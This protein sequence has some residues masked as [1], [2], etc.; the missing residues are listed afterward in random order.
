MI[1][2]VSYDARHSQNDDKCLQISE[3]LSLIPE[4]CIYTHTHKTTEDMCVHT[5]PHTPNAVSNRKAALCG[6]G[7]VVVASGLLQVASNQLLPL[8][9]PRSLPT[10]TNV[11]ASL[12]PLLKLLHFR[13][14]FVITSLL[15]NPG[16]SRLPL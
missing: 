6:L 3:H 8:S 9:N 10:V 11:H 15:F 7:E 5:P 1:S 2:Q 16:D 12:L 4:S 13:S 14:L